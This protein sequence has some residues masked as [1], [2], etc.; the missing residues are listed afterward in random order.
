MRVA[1]WLRLAT[2]ASSTS[3]RSLVVFTVRIGIL[4]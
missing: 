3:L 1:G 4:L 2:P